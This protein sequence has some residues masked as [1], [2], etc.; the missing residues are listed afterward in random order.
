M[1]VEIVAFSEQDIQ[2]LTSKRVGETKLGE[3]VQV[4]FNTSSKYVLI[5][6]QEDIGPQANFGK[7]GATNA[8]TAMLSRFLNMQA[9]RFFNGKQLC[10]A[11]YIKQLTS[12]QS[13]EQGREFVAHLDELLTQLLI[14]IYEKNQIPILIG[15]GH[16]NAY[17]LIKAY[18]IAKKQAIE[19]INLDPHADYRALEG[20]HS[21]NSFSYAMSEGF[22]K[23]YAV[24]GL[25]HAY[26]SE[27]MLQNMESNGCYFTFFEDY[28]SQ[29]R[30]LSNDID[31][32]IHRNNHALGIELDLDAIQ[33]MPSSAYTPSGISVETAR[34][35]IQQLTK[36]KRAIA[37]LHLPEG[38]ATNPHEEL[39]IGKTLAY[40]VRDFV[41]QDENQ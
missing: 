38:S 20:R 41:E 33:N 8:F 28:I 17:P 22:L 6:V 18:S 30:N 24:L 31:T 5:G 32:I 1:E 39:I 9:N 14:P 35:Y 21:G 25:H 12:F 7:P 4:G 3:H 40:L 37:Y 26:N 13:I 29:N 15:G 23:H 10:C 11:G 34:N 27:A 19:V 2:Q 16:N 36:S